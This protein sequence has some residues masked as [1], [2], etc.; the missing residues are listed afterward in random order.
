MRIVHEYERLIYYAKSPHSWAFPRNWI[1]LC[2]KYPAIARNKV[3]ENQ[4]EPMNIKYLNDVNANNDL[5]VNAS[6]SDSSL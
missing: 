4:V 2:E 3:R 1:E 6:S 5:R